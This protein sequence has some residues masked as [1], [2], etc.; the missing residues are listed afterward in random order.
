MSSV[1]ARVIWRNK[2]NS[3]DRDTDVPVNRDIY[4]QRD[5]LC[6]IGLCHY[7]G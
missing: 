7:G 3:T 1:L 4:S 2:T 6:G 5:L